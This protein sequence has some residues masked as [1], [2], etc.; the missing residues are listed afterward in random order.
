MIEL[1]IDTS[2]CVLVSFQFDRKSL[3]PATVIV[4]IG[5]MRRGENVKTTERSERI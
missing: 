2:E 3:L 4:E 1:A 5:Q